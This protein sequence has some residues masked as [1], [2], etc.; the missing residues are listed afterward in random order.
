MALDP[1]TA[2]S[3]AATVVQ[4]VDFSCKL[5]SKGHE[6]YASADGASVGNREVELIAKDLRNLNARLNGSVA[7]RRAT[8]PNLTN[9]EKALVDL[10]LNCSAV[11]DELLVVLDQLKVQGNSNRR[12]KSFR[13]ALQSLLKKGKV[14]EINLRLQAIRQELTFHVLV[15]LR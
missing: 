10:S 1:L 5:L 6:I 13:Q 8:N 2:L 12:W 7:T 4:F 9:S 14:D 3:L 15:S 11:A